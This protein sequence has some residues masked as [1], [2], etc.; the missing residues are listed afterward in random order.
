MQKIKFKH[1]EMIF[2]KEEGSEISVDL[3][4][5]EDNENKEVR[6]EDIQAY[7]E[8]IKNVRNPLGF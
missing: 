3:D 1:G 6:R 5:A 7:F 4:F 2:E 8:E